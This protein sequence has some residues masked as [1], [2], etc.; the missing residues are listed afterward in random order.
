MDHTKRSSKDNKGEVKPPA[1]T[2]VVNTH[3]EGTSGLRK[4]GTSHDRP[5]PNSKERIGLDSETMKL[6]SEC[7]KVGTWNVRTLYQAGKLDNCSII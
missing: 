3:K 5:S 4:S 7:L 1:A 6:R 2:S